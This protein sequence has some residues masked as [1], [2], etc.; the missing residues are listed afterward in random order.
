ML[1]TKNLKLYIK[2]LI[3]PLGSY[4]HIKINYFIIAYHDHFVIQKSR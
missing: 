4:K 2:S 3:L 1:I